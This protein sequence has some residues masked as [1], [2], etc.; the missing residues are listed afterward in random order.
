MTSVCGSSAGRW[1]RVL[2]L[3]TTAL[4]AALVLVALPA[5]SAHAQTTDPTECA[6]ARSLFG[7]DVQATVTT[8]SGTVSTG[9]EAQ[10]YSGCLGNTEC[11][12]DILYL[13]GWCLA[14][15]AVS[16]D[17]STNWDAQ[18]NYRGATAVCKY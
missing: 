16:V 15:H 11:L 7:C 6:T 4:L 5:S 13:V 8:L 10:T 2:A 3:G 17:L 14:R 18:G 9:A 12:G 1:P